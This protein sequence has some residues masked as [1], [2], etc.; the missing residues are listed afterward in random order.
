MW[1]AAYDYTDDEFLKG[2][3]AFDR[4]S[5]DF[6]YVGSPSDVLDSCAGPETKE[7][8]CPPEKRVCHIDHATEWKFVP[9]RLRNQFNKNLTQKR[10]VKLKKYLDPKRFSA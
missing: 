4:C 6:V 3:D 1:K 10:F 7:L 9:G 8:G 5:E 2:T